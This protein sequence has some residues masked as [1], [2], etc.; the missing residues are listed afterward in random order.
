MIASDYFIVK[1]DNILSI[2][3][4]TSK[5]LRIALQEQ[6]YGIYKDKI[7]LESGTEVQREILFKRN[8]NIW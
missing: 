6:T 4:H 7:R 5:L 1:S 3:P 2:D 8:K